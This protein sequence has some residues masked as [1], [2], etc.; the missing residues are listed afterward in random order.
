MSLW[1]GGAYS[2]VAARGAPSCLLPALHAG[3]PAVTE[4][5]WAACSFTVGTLVVVRWRGSH[6]HC[7]AVAAPDCIS[8]ERVAPWWGANV[9]ARNVAVR[10]TVAEGLPVPPLFAEMP[11]LS[12]SGGAR[13]GNSFRLRSVHATSCLF[14]ARKFSLSTYCMGKSQSLHSTHFKRQSKNGSTRRVRQI[15]SACMRVLQRD[16]MVRNAALLTIPL[17]A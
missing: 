17:S 15:R 12:A 14:A 4:S 8:G 5:R 10:A 3:A 2:T 13:R 7:G 11:L 6:G 9:A 1:R 16:A